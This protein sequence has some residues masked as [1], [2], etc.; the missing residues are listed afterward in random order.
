LFDAGNG[1]AT[2]RLPELFTSAFNYKGLEGAMVK[3]ARHG[4]FSAEDLQRYKHAWRQPG[5]LKAMINWYKAY[6]YNTIDWHPPVTTP[7]LIIWGRKDAFL[8][9]QMAYASGKK[10]LNARLEMI[11]DATHWLHHEQPERVNSLI[12]RFVAGNE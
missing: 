5:A 8:R 1:S 9:H 6:K 7:A 11:P 10:C 2:K 4:S 3:T 12:H